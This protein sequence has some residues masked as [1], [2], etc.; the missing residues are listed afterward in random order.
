M[1]TKHLILIVL[2]AVLI[3]AP[4]ALAAPENSSRGP[5]GG[6][7]GS[8]QGQGPMAMGPQNPGSGGN[9][10]Q[11]LLGRM[12][13]RLGLSNEQKKNIKAIAKKAKRKMKENREAIQKAMQAFQKA[14][15]DGTEAEIIAAG[16]VAGDALIEQALNRSAVAKKIKAELTEK[17]NAQLKEMK[18]KMKKRM[19]QMQQNRGQQNAGLG[20]GEGPRNSEGRFGGGR[21]ERRGPRPEY[22]EEDEDY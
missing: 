1:K 9:I 11:M 3:L 5:R 17:Q 14:T 19:Q 10:A 16:K 22:S 20:R 8:G 6:Q 18:T 13:E 7:D 4:L 2:L 21:G 12:G 15:E